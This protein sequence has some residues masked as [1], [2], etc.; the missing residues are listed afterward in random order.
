MHGV[1]F[2]GLRRRPPKPHGKVIFQ[3]IPD[4]GE[5][6][7]RGDEKIRDGWGRESRVRRV[8]K[9]TCVPGGGPGPRDS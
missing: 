8:E 2:Q 4:F 9:K 7:L 1:S 5:T 6:T 3:E